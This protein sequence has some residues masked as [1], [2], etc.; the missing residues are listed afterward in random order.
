MTSRLPARVLLAL[1]T[2]LAMVGLT[3]APARA[4]S[5]PPG[6]C[7][8][9]LSASRTQRAQICVYFEAR[10]YSYRVTGSIAG[11]RG[12]GS[13]KLKI[14][15]VG[16]QKCYYADNGACNWAVAGSTNPSYPKVSTSG[17]VPESTP[18][19]SR[20]YGTEFGCEVV[21]AFI[22]WTITFSSGGTKSG[23]FWTSPWQGSCI[24]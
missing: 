1:G 9:S 10:T 18:W 20:P 2:C 5:A 16:K 8:D 6:Y 22:S 23:F 3:A 4:E 21:R 12:I 14:V 13:S 24:G 15:R 11:Y 17:Y 7:H 19:Y